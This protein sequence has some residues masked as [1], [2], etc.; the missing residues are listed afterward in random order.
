[1]FFPY[2]CDCEFSYLRREKRNDETQTFKLNHFK[3]TNSLVYFK[4][5]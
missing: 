1:M 3:N 4:S 5:M 2:L